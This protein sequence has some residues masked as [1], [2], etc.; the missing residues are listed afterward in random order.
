LIATALA[1]AATAV[2][3]LEVKIRRLA[4]RFEIGSWLFSRQPTHF[5]NAFFMVPPFG[6]ERC[7]VGQFTKTRRLIN[8]DERRKSS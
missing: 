5:P 2:M 6:R 8:E 4:D 3:T 7:T 1:A